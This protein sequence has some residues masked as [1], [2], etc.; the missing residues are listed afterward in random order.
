MDNLHSSAFGVAMYLRLDGKFHTRSYTCAGSID[1]NQAKTHALVRVAMFL[2]KIFRVT[3][4]DWCI[5]HIVMYF[6]LIAAEKIVVDSSINYLLSSV[7][8]SCG[9]NCSPISNLILH[10][11]FRKFIMLSVAV[12]QGDMG[13][14]LPYFFLSPT[15]FTPKSFQISEQ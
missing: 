2:F 10:F 14:P 8:S 1:K 4:N 13:I 5:Q 7:D 15:K 12:P 11:F 9:D 6:Q 3:T